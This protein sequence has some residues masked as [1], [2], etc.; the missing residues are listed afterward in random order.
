MYML[1]RP[2][3]FTVYIGEPTAPLPSTAPSERKMY[4]LGLTKMLDLTYNY[5]RSLNGVWPA[6]EYKVYTRLL[7]PCVKYSGFHRPQD[8]PIRLLVSE[9]DLQAELRRRVQ[10]LLAK[11]VP[12]ANAAAIM[13]FV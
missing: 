10:R 8:V 7:G 3:S 11:K 5:Q 12:E 2:N 1:L 13:S 4:N 9:A 6:L